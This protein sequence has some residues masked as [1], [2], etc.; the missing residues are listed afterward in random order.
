MSGSVHVTRF[1][2]LQSLH[3]L[4]FFPP[5][6]FG[7]RLGRKKPAFWN[8]FVSDSIS[9]FSCCVWFPSQLV[10]CSL[11]DIYTK[12]LL[13]L[14]FLLGSVIQF[15]SLLQSF[16]FTYIFVH[17]NFFLSW[18]AFLFLFSKPLPLY[19]WTWDNIS[20]ANIHRL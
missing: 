12:K 3:N 1:N 15:Q 2:F 11:P 4:V 13:T 16:L 19:Q 18:F 6:M 7:L 10:H 20:S 14:S 8:S 5:G 17:N 9:L